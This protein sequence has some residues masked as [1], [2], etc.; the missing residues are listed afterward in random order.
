MNKKGASKPDNI[1]GPPGPD[2]DEKILKL[3]GYLTNVIFPIIR[4]YGGQREDAGDIAQDTLA[5]AVKSARTYDP[6]KGTLAQWLTG[7]ARNEAF[8]FIREQKHDYELLKKWVSAEKADALI[9]QNQKQNNLLL[10]VVEDCLQKPLFTDTD[11]R[12]YHLRYREQKSLQTIAKELHFSYPV[13]RV[14]LTRLIQKV[15]AVLH[16]I[17][18]DD[19]FDVG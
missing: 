5:K 18:F 2:T 10:A 12:I 19:A 7:I 17:D 14:R 6:A 11:R 4:G 1:F 9:N 15:A 16:K 3:Y 8:Q 13:L